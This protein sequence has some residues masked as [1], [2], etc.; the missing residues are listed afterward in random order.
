MSRKHFHL[1]VANS[2]RT[3][4]YTV[5]GD[6]S[7]ESGSGAWDL[8]E[9]I[10]AMRPAW[11]R[12]PNRNCANLTPSAFYGSDRGVL[13]CEGCPVQQPCLDYAVEHGEFGVWGGMSERQRRIIRRKVI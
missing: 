10:Y 6:E 8:I 12:D 1:S 11:M 9:A 7:S 3:P 5:T 4:R 2:P 13:V